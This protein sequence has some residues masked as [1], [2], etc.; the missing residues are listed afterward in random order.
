MP[1]LSP[2]PSLRLHA[3]YNPSQIPAKD[4]TGIRP[5]PNEG[6]TP[7]QDRAMKALDLALNIHGPGFN[8]YLAGDAYLGRCYMLVKYLTPLARKMKTPPDLVYVQNF[9]DPESPRL[10]E[11]P[12]GQG[13][14][15]R[16][17]LN[18]CLLA[19]EKE[20]EH[21]LSGTTF[22]RQREKLLQSCQT[23]RNKILH[24]MNVAA[25]HKGFNCDVDEN[26]NISLCPLI[27]GKRASE[28]EFAE[29]DA[30]LKLT[31]KHRSETLARHMTGLV[32]ELGRTEDGFLDQ[33]KELE[34]QLMGSVLNV[35]LTPFAKRMQKNCPSQKVGDYFL[36][37]RDDILKN[38]NMLLEHEQG[39]EP[40]TGTPQPSVQERVPLHM[41]Y[42]IN[43]FV[44]N[45]NLKGAPII[46]EDHPSSTN[47]LGCIE[48]ESELGA[49][50]T[51]FSLIKSGSLHKA[52]GG[53]LVL[54]MEDVLHYPAAWEGLLR[55][56]KSSLARMEDTSDAPD[57]AV[58]TKGLRPDP[59]P[60]D[61]KVILIGDEFLYEGLLDSD[62]RFSKLFRIKAEMTDVMP[63]SA[64]GIRFYLGAISR[65]ITK[66]NLPPF[67]NTALA[68]LIDLGSHICE[69]QK[70]L[71]QKFPILR[72]HMIEASATA[73][74]RGVTQVTGAVLEE[75]YTQ[76]SY[77]TNL[78]EELYMEEYDRDTIKVET[79]G[80]AI[81]QVNGLAVTTYGNFEFGLPHRISCTVGVGHDGIIDLEREADLGGPIHTKA[82]MILVSYLT[83]M[84]ASRKPLMLSGSLFF[85]QSY[86]G[87]EG[88]SASGAELAALLSA[89]AETPIR[90]DL[91]FTGA[92][93]HSGQIMAV[94]GVTQK[95]EGFFKVCSRQRLTGTQGVIIPADNIDQ[96][97]L[98]PCVLD[99]VD[100]GQFFIYP[101]R[102]IEDAL[103]LLTGMAAG[104]RRKNGT[105]TKGSLYE[106]V[107][108]RLERL[109]EYGQ[110]AF[111][112]S[113]HS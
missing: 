91:A 20:I 26:G 78:I 41:R 94:G 52:S 40:R 71:S 103:Y 4:S 106:L 86:A 50:V 107:D 70:K 7:F 63:R 93:S 33:E 111:R 14:R 87:I 42:R 5:A 62:D 12:A 96:L 38:T 22:L 3:T 77:R 81:G 89:L 32:Q 88:D 43:L 17:G 101:V 98:A 54:H 73:K 72:E 9:S 55:A 34:R 45:G 36:K 51:D 82:M 67:D 97:M 61:L 56:L 90:L 48:R 66:E 84:F 85:E 110:N 69:D 65:I 19:V 59:V 46:V 100:K 13:K 92:V 31:L 18:D 10:L 16:Q 25:E 108:N 29:L 1:T 102:H 53:Y 95:I 35:L 11:L 60:L 75:A 64:A 6:R 21:K 80:Q 57:T 27:R 58:R 39:T 74:L 79:S 24:R 2:L 8:I 44:D 83:G 47:L 28:D 76:R 37:L 112:R 99:A 68:W 104:K 30:G 49:L 113:R 23:A 109:G 105:F 15:L